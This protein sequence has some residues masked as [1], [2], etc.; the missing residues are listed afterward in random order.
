MFFILRYFFSGRID[1][2]RIWHTFFCKNYNISRVNACI[3][4]SKVCCISS[5]FG[6][7]LGR[8]FRTAALCVVII[9]V[10]N[11][12][13][14]L[15]WR[16]C[17]IEFTACLLG[18]IVH[19][20]GIQRTIIIQSDGIYRKVQRYCLFESLAQFFLGFFYC[21]WSF[22]KICSSVAEQNDHR[23]SSG[24]KSLSLFQK[25][26]GFCKSQ[27]D[28]G[29]I[30]D[31]IFDRSHA[32]FECIFSGAQIGKSHTVKNN[33]GIIYI[34]GSCALCTGCTQFCKELSG[35]RCHVFRVCPLHG[36]TSVD[37]INDIQIQIVF[38]R[39][40]CFFCFYRYSC[41]TG[42]NQQQKHY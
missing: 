29:I 28:I 36:T 21:T 22:W 24:I 30:I 34:T 5:C 3:V 38:C 42:N 17:F 11:N 18:N 2:L 12:T 1:D 37:D 10:F 35:S 40:C 6:I 31:I 14:Q 8:K 7:I 15:I 27:C 19:C 16:F 39:R 20:S 9:N 32:F 26:Y 25:F 13:I 23:I 41:H 4:N 33:M